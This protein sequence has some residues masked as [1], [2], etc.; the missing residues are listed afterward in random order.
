MML[1][2]PSVAAA[3]RASRGGRPRLGRRRNTSGGHQNA[4]KRGNC[5]HG[6]EP[7]FSMV[8]LPISFV[9]MGPGPSPAA[10]PARAGVSRHRAAERRVPRIRASVNPEA[11]RSNSGPE[12]R[13]GHR[14]VR[15]I[16]RITYECIDERGRHIARRAASRRRSSRRWLPGG[17]SRGGDRSPEGATGPAG[18]GVR[19]SGRAGG[20]GRRPRCGWRRRACPARG[21]RAF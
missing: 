2:L 10:G 12:G 9:T 17:V 11:N 13:L 4:R 21:S 5:E 1:A 19:G 3:A 8:D 6:D 16:C 18:G 20:P 15:A 7:V 14:R